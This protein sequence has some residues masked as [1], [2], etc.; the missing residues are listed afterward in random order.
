MKATL[1]TAFLLLSTTLS[2]TDLNLR[3]NP[4]YMIVGAMNLEL[5]VGLGSRWSLGPSVT[6]NAV[7]DEFIV[8]ARI[9]RF[10]QPRRES[11]W[12]TGL[13]V[14]H[15]PDGLGFAD[16]FTSVRLLEHYQW[17]GEHF[18]LAVGIGPDLRLMGEEDWR[19]WIG[20]DLGLGWRF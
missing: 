10:R 12:Y 7:L 13:A 4:G 17:H 8:G 3:T 11:G 14:R 19:L 16:A 15:S 2:A 6:A 18:N 9:H 1:L 20:T 5:D